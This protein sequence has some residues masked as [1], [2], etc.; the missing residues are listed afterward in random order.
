MVHMIHQTGLWFGRSGRNKNEEFS[1]N[2]AI[3]LQIHSFAGGVVVN[4]VRRGG[5]KSCGDRSRQ[6]NH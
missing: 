4:V 3:S 6:A 2:K 1:F 5:P